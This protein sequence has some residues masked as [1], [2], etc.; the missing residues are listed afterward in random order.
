MDARSFQV[1]IRNS[2]YTMI[3]STRLNLPK[4]A[5]ADI[6]IVK[7][8]M[9]SLMV[10]H[11]AAMEYAGF[12]FKHPP[13]PSIT[14]VQFHDSTLDS[15]WLII[16]DGQRIYFVQE[17][18]TDERTG[19]AMDENVYSFEHV[20]FVHVDANR[21]DP[22]LI[23]RV[24]KDLLFFWAMVECLLLSPDDQLIRRIEQHAVIDRGKRVTIPPF[25]EVTVPDDVAYLK[26]AASRA[27]SNA[28]EIARM[29]AVYVRTTLTPEDG[30]Q[31]SGYKITCCRCGKEDE[32]VASGHTGSLPQSVINKKFQQK[33]WKT[34]RKPIG[35]CC[36]VQ[37]PARFPTPQNSEDVMKKTIDADPVQPLAIE[38]PRQMTPA[39]KRKVFRAIDDQWDEKHGRYIGAASDQHVAST[40]GVPRAWV[41]EV[42]EENFGKTQRNEDL[43][44]ALG[45]LK[46]VKGEITRALDKVLEFA[47]TLE[48]LEKKVELLQARV[49]AV[50]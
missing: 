22:D 18:T 14:E 45:E 44:K 16:N 12:V 26:G 8:G 31:R 28:K 2:R 49:E 21:P 24:H 46:N 1:T 3:N 43:D 15:P 17:R 29:N 47:T 13:K 25:V 35:P 30:Q 37:R 9:D 33:G 6:R 27:E 36:S 48:A 41:V 42:R 39:D 10:R 7:F 40:L 34:G 50:E 5:S 19:L 20:N 32:I 4:L 11:M 38:A 23:K